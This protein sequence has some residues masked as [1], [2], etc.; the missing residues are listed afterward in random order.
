VTHSEAG[1]KEADVEIG[2]ML[3]WSIGWV[4]REDDRSI[5]IINEMDPED[6]QHLHGQV[7]LKST[8]ETSSLV[9]LP[10]AVHRKGT[11]D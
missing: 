4:V 9:E 2:P 3:V 1:W 7:I 10:D 5:Y 11:S 6:G 8:I